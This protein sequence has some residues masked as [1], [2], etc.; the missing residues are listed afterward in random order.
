MD[1]SEMHSHKYACLPMRVSSR[2]LMHTQARLERVCEHPQKGGELKYT[3][4]TFIGH[5]CSINKNE[6]IS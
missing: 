6:S 2:M 1:G 3:F 4:E 5:T